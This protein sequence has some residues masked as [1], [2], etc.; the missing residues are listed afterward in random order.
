[1]TIAVLLMA[2][3]L[4]SAKAVCHSIFHSVG[5]IVLTNRENTVTMTKVSTTCKNPKPKTC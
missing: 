2:M 1:M 5:A 4:A 3:A